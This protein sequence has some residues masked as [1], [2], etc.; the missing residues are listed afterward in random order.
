MTKI[1]HC[2]GVEWKT[3]TQEVKELYRTGQYGRAVTVAEA[4]L[5]VAEQNVGPDHPEVAERLENLA[6]LYRATR[7]PAEAE[8]LEARANYSPTGLG[9]CLRAC[10]TARCL[11][12]QV[13]K[14]QPRVVLV[15][16]VPAGTSLA[17]L[18][19]RRAGPPSHRRIV[20]L[21]VADR[22]GAQGGTHE[23]RHEPH[24]P[25]LVR[26]TPLGR[27]LRHSDGSGTPWTQRR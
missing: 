7:R 19:D 10:R 4:A 24:I 15:I 23:A 22:R 25:A 11:G 9:R 3:L 21:A 18:Q 20:V 27:R 8:K 16:R 26:D 5:K 2:A 1:F 6:A 12:S 17:Q 13:P 14:C